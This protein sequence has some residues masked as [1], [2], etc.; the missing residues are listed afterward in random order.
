MINAAFSFFFEKMRLC[1][2][3]FLGP[4]RRGKTVHFLGR[5]SQIENQDLRYQSYQESPDEF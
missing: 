5:A 4:K 3:F 2:R 1:A